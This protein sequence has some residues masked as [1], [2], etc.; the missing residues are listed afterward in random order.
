MQELTQRG[1]TALKGGDR[2]EAL[3][4][5][6]QAVKEQPEDTTAWLWLSGAVEK[7]D[8]RIACL[9]QVLR[10]D[11]Q[12][13]AA[14]RGLEKLQGRNPVSIP[15]SPQPTVPAEQTPAPATVPPETAQS[16]T[17]IPPEPDF[18]IAAAAPLMPLQTQAQ[19]RK[20][21]PVLPGSDLSAQRVFR[22]RPSLV[23]ALACFWIFFLGTVFLVSLLSGLNELGYFISA[24]IGIFLEIIVIFVIVRN[25]RTQY[26]LTDQYLSLPFRGKKSRIPVSD[27]LHMEIRRSFWQKIRGTADILLDGIVANELTTLR[28]RDIPGYQKRVDQIKSLAGNVD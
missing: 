3:K 28:M 24:G 20:R 7:D 27:L 10:I 23:P 8:Q 16:S 9:R 26:E 15:P 4:L 18:Q 5:L 12:N 22:I 2:T 17:L 21:N 1:I 14:V 6:S 13:Q 11:P 19:S 25:F